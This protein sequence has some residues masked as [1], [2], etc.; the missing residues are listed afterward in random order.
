MSKLLIFII[1]FTSLYAHGGGGNTSILY[2]TIKTFLNTTINLITNPIPKLPDES[3]PEPTGAFNYAP[4][5][6]G[7]IGVT[8]ATG[9][10]IKYACHKYNQRQNNRG[11]DAELTK[12]ITETD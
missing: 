2:P 11:H 3:Q 1:F 8:A 9:V 10:V 5:V 7:A 12:V 6:C 4:Y